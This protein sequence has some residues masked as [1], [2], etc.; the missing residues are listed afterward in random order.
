MQA[1]YKYDLKLLITY[2]G[3]NYC[4][5]S[6][7]QKVDAILATYLPN[8]GYCIDGLEISYCGNNSGHNGERFEYYKWNDARSIMLT[9][10]K[11][12][13]D[14]WPPTHKLQC[15]PTRGAALGI[16]QKLLQKRKLHWEKQSQEFKKP[17]YKQQ[18]PL[19]N[20]ILK[21]VF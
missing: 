12:A 19:Q 13:Y 7:Q 11:W 20:A 18:H 6:P 9:P 1:A 15:Q 4:D 16:K 2:E 17:L 5:M 21:Y 14:H 10:K 8:A 3:P